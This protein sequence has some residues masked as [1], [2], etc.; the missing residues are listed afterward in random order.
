MRILLAGPPEALH[1]DTDRALAAMYLL[2]PFVWRDQGQW[3]IAVRAVPRSEK[4]E[5]KVSRVHFGASENGVRFRLDDTASLSPGPGADDHDGCE[6]PTVV[7]IGGGHR[8]FYSG[9]DQSRE[10]GELLSA[11]TDADPGPFRKLGRVLPQPNRFLNAKEASVA[12]AE[13]GRWRLIFEYSNNGHSATAIAVADALGGP[14]TPLEDPL[15]GRPGSWDDVHLSPGPVMVTSDG[16]RLLFYNGANGQTQWRIGWAQL[17][18]NCTSIVT[19]CT[20]PLI[21]P[22]KP[23]GDA[24]DIAFCSSVVPDSDQLWLYYTVSDKDCFRQRVFVSA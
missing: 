15:V 13:D 21:T 8:V 17:D 16:L 20:E 1:F 18:A 9:W 22:P 3:R 7:Q 2:S 23:V 24:S 12:Q 10:Q 6:D 11:V 14:W 4:K 19:R 5:E